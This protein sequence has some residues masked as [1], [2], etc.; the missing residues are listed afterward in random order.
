MSETLSAQAEDKE[1]G[2][3]EKHHTRI[4]E[5]IR[6][7]HKRA[8]QNFLFLKKANRMVTAPKE[9]DR[10]TNT[11]ERMTRLKVMMY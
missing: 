4:S 9:I 6:L 3:L 5:R 2:L 7:V 10:M 1:R 11:I 8:D